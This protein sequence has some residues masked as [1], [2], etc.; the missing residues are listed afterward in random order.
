MANKIDKPQFTELNV[1]LNFI[2]TFTILI[3]LMLFRN[4]QK[5][6]NNEIDDSQSTPSDYTIMVSNI[7][8]LPSDVASDLRDI[9]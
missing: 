5:K 2:V 3:C 1:N 4:S 9:F 8:I 6:I 7:P